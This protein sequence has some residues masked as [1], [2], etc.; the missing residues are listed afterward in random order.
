MVHPFFRNADFICNDTLFYSA[1]KSNHA[2]W[3]TVSDAERGL[4]G[5][6]RSRTVVFVGSSPL[7]ISYPISN[8]TIRDT[9]ISKSRLH[10]VI[11]ICSRASFSGKEFNNRALLDE[12]VIRRHFFLTY[13]GATPLMSCH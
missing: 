6:L 10:S 1:I 9:H 4:P 12:K 13:Q 8:C 3:W 11:D 2:S 7:K 5:R